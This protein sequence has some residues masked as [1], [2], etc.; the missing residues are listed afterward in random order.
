VH[1]KGSEESCAKPHHLI[2]STEHQFFLETLPID[3]IMFRLTL[4][5][6]VLLSTALL[7]LLGG[8]PAAQA[9]MTDADTSHSPFGIFLRRLGRT[10]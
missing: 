2:I 5:P 9:R 10:L 1:E 7:V 6:A 4:I 3:I 8:L